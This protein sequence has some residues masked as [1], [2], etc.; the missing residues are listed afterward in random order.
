MYKQHFHKPVGEGN[1]KQENKAVKQEIRVLNIF[2]QAERPLARWEVYRIY[3]DIYGHVKEHS[4]VRAISNLLNGTKNSP[5]Y[6]RQYDKVLGDAG[7]KVNRWV[8][9]NKPIQTSLF[10]EIFQ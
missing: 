9:I 4:I 3:K 10:N 8:L 6:I 1:P 7:V 2:K 5:V